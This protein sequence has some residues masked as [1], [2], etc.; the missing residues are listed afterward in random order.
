MGGRGGDCFLSNGRNVVDPTRNV[1]FLHA[2][3]GSCRELISVLW[4]S[5]KR[6]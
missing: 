2:I 4:F 1:I 6:V 5:V 3:L